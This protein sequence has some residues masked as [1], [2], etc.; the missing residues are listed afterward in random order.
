MKRVRAIKNS[1]T[2]LL[3]I[4]KIKTETKIA[5]KKANIFHLF[6]LNLFTIIKIIGVKA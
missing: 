1:E 5:G 3:K 2:D 6:I 4:N